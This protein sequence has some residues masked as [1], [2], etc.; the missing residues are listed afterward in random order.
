MSTRSGESDE[1]MLKTNN[2]NSS[3]MHTCVSVSAVALQRVNVSNVDMS[4]SLV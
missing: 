4:F 3:V 2:H 1:V